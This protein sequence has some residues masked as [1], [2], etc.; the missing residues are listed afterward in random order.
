M[1]LLVD[2]RMIAT[3]HAH[4]PSHYLS[5]R[6]DNSVWK[7][8]RDIAADLIAAIADAIAADRAAADQQHLAN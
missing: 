7:E 1:N 8:F 5:K 6:P 3:P 4:I 2:Q